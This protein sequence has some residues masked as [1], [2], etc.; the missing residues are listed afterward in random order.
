MSCSAWTGSLATAT[1]TN[2]HDKTA[3]EGASY[4]YSVAAVDGFGTEGLSA[5]V[6]VTSR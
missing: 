5:S 3:V 4:V 6:P 2:Y 1:R